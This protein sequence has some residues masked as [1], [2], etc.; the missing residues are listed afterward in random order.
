MPADTPRL[1]RLREVE[2]R[3][4]RVRLGAVAFGSLEVESV[5]EQGS[6]F[7]LELPAERS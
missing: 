1:A 4:A 7:R 3:I 5:P 6:V 2:I